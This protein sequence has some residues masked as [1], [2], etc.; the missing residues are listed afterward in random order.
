MTACD[1]SLAHLRTDRL[2]AYLLHWRGSIPLEEIIAAFEQLQG[3]GKILSW[4]QQLR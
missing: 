1:R 4:G 2:D 3:E